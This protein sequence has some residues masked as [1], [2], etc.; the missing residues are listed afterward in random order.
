MK[1][2]AARP[3]L[4]SPDCAPSAGELGRCRMSR[5]CREPVPERVTFL[6]ISRGPYINNPVRLRPA[7]L[8]LLHETRS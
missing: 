5:A 7:T 2:R 3:A 8:E 4:S 1:E 6:I